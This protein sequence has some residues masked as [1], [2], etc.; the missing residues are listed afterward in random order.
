MREVNLTEAT[1]CRTYFGLAMLS[2]NF[3]GYIIYPG[4]IYACLLLTNA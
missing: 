2:K 4:Q 3:L 1:G